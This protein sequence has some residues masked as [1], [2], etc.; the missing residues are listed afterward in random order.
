MLDPDRS[1]D[2]PT[3]PSSSPR[4]RAAAGRPIG[5]LGRAVVRPVGFITGQQGRRDAGDF[6][7][8]A[9][10]G[11]SSARVALACRVPRQERALV[12]HS[13]SLRD[14]ART[15]TAAYHRY[16]STGTGFAGR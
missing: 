6:H 15:A 1:S 16:P 3:R 7:R 14:V 11:S 9:R 4:V 13:R 5:S 12:S 2:H 10:S 8:S